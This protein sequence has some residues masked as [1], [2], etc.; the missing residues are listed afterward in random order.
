[1]D[2]GESSSRSGTPRRTPY[3]DYPCPPQQIQVIILTLLVSYVSVRSTCTCTE[4][5]S[6]STAY[7]PVHAFR[8]VL[9]LEP[10]CPEFLFPI[11]AG[12]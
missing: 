3:L 2:R 7:K 11:P 8:G 9:L 6:I 1:M 10:T 4:H 12:R 5:P